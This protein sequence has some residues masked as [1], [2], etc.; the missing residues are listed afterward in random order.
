MSPSISQ[1]HNRSDI[2]LPITQKS[3][4][5]TRVVLSF[6]NFLQ[7]KIRL[8]RNGYN[9]NIIIGGWGCVC[10]MLHLRSS[11]FQYSGRSDKNLFNSVNLVIAQA[12]FNSSCLNRNGSQFVSTRTRPLSRPGDGLRGYP[13]KLGEYPATVF[14]RTAKPMV[15]GV[16]VLQ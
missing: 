7:S 14:K 11:K 8:I 10:F 2:K 12:N 13:A 3:K 6:Q 5:A 16:G 9:S 15:R 4:K 1:L